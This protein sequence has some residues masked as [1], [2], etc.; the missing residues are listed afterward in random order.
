[1]DREITDIRAGRLE[2]LNAIQ[3]RERFYQAE[4]TAHKLLADVRQVELETLVAAVGGLLNDA[5]EQPDSMDESIKVYQT[6]NHLVE[7]LR[8]YLDGQAWLENKRIME[9]IHGIKKQA[10]TLK[11]EMPDSPVIEPLGLSDGE[12]NVEVSALF[13]QTYT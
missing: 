3:V 12:A 8:K 10:I 1:M 6:N 13:R 11:D 2:T 5:Q 7:Q 9:L 4:D